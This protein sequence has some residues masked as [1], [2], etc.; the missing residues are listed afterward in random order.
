MQSP[1]RGAARSYLGEPE[2]I[3]AAAIYLASDDSK[4]FTG[5]V[6]VVD[7]GII[8]HM[9]YVAENIDAFFEN[10]VKRRV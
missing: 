9:P 3:A 8:D 5:Q 10:S 6:M 1:R 2:D 7:G 4:F